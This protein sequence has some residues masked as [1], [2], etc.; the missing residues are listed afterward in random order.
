M[1]HLISTPMFLFV[2]VAVSGVV[3]VVAC[4]ASCAFYLARSSNS[5]HCRSFSLSSEF[6]I[7]VQILLNWLRTLLRRTGLGTFYATRRTQTL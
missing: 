1:A 3:L 4:F 6:D 5:L 2:A 7:S